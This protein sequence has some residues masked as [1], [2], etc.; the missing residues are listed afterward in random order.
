MPSVLW[1]VELAE[2]D[3]IVIKGR[4]YT[5]L[6]ITSSADLTSADRM[7]TKQHDTKHIMHSISAAADFT[8]TVNWRVQKSIL[9]E[10]FEG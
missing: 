8:F 2:R 7:A 10:L 9:L 6:V 3:V 4:I 5:P 1:A